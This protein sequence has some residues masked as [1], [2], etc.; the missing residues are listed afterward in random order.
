MAYKVKFGKIVREPTEGEIE[1]ACRELDPRIKALV[2]NGWM[3]QTGDN[4][5]MSEKF[6][7]LHA[8]LGR[9]V[10]PEDLEAHD[11]MTGNQSLSQLEAEFER[12]ERFDH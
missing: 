7:K 1:L 11:R 10:M 9:E 3:I 6:R 4:L 8:K 5:E 12:A 2:T